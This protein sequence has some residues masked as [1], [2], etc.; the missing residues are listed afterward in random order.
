M[1]KL[2]VIIPIASA[3]LSI[4]DLAQDLS[5]LPR[6]AEVIFVVSDEAQFGDEKEQL[7]AIFEKQKM[8]WV[9]SEEGRAAA[10]NTG[11]E[12]STSDL[13]WFVHA[14][15]RL[16]DITINRMMESI[17]NTP[18][19]IWFCGLRYLNDG[20]CQMGF[21]QLGANIRSRLFKIPF[22]DQGICMSKKIFYILGG[23][24]QDVEFG[25]D[26][27]LIWQAK[28]YK[29]PIKHCGGTVWTSARKYKEEGWLTLTWQRQLMW[30]QQAW[31]EFCTYVGA[32][33]NQVRQR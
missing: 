29:I 5:H 8:Q 10:L 14:D 7:K 11:V 27:L 25:E 23:Y 31:P 30:L 3:E 21:S 33:Y 26:H 20:P 16:C 18:D 32:F 24:R 15:S 19:T 1:A 22:G 12:V 28:H 13:L 2:S 17:T 4:L 6:D 9:L